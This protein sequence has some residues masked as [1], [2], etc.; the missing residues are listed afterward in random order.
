MPHFLYTDVFLRHRLQHRFLEL[1]DVICP[2]ETELAL[3]CK[4]D[5]DPDNDESVCAGARELIERGYAF[6]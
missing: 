1:S 2:N 5:V 3:L 6:C 4:G